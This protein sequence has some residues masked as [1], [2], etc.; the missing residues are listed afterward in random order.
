MSTVPRDPGLQ[1]ERTAL[2][3]R[4]T[5]ATA[6]CVALLLAHHTAQRLG[7]P[8]ATAPIVSSVCLLVLAF[9]G[10]YRGHRVLADHHSSARAAALFT[11]VAVAA[12]SGTIAIGLF[13]G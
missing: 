12:A 2:A 6:A 13:F 3:W 1:A 5:A 7:I 11:S 4:R 10:H 9:V 8:A